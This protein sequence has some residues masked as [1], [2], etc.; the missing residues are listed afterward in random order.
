MATVKADIDT[1]I[2]KAKLLNENL[3]KVAVE[4]DYLASTYS[5]I[6]DKTS[7]LN[8]ANAN[9]AKESVDIEYRKIADAKQTL[10]S[11]KAGRR[12]FTRRG[13]KFTHRNRY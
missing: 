8:K 4:F 13:R 6:R 9:S 12:K 5:E 7:E 10:C 2:A 1:W 11:M 3:S